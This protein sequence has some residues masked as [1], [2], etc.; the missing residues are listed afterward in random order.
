MLVRKV[1]SRRVHSISLNATFSEIVTILTKHKIG[2]APVV[3]K[4]GKVVG[5]VSEK[6]LFFK[7]YPS[8][9]DFYTDPE[10]YMNFDRLERD[11]KGIKKLKAKDFMSKEVI[12]VRSD[13]HILKV[14]S[15][16]IRHKI[17]RLPV[18]DDGQ[19]VGIVTTNKIYRR[20]LTKIVKSY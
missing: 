3:D 8:Q 13:D 14:C 11:A 1:M 16:F 20:F 9:K 5:I 15:L 12:S 7:L 19:L 17:R 2:G 4:K 10:Y 6:D 18:I